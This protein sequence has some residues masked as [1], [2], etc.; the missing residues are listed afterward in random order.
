[1]QN[2]KLLE[3]LRYIQPEE[4]RNYL[5]F[6]RS[7]FYASN[8]LPERLFNNIYKYHP[9]YT[10]SMLSKEKAFKKIFPREKY[11]AHKMRKLMHELKGL[12]E[13]Y[14]IARQVQRDDFQKKQLLLAEYRN[15]NMYSQFKK[16]TTDLITE[17]EASPHRD[18]SFYKNMHALQEGFYDHPLTN[19]EKK[20]ISFLLS[21]MENLDYYYLLH[22]QRFRYALIWAKK[23]LNIKAVPKS[24]K[25]N[26]ETMQTL[27]LF[28]MYD[29][30]SQ[31]HKIPEDDALYDTAEKT[32]KDQIDQLAK[33]DQ[34]DIIRILTNH[35][36]NQYNRG[37]TELQSKLFELHQFGL[38]HELFI[39]NQQ[40]GTHLFTNVVTI[41]ILEQK[42]DW[43]EQFIKQYALY[44]A[45]NLRADTVH[46]SQ[47][48]LSLHRKQYQRTI[49][50][51]QTYKFS[52]ILLVLRSKGILLRACFELFSQDSTY[53]D[54]LI[55]QIEAFKKFIRRHQFI[56]EPK[57][58]T[59]LHF[60]SF[61]Q[62]LATQYLKR[63]LDQTLYHQI[64]VAD[65]IVLKKWLLQQC[66][67]LLKRMG[68]KQ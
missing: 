58:Q 31:M 59:Y 23:L 64:E 33:K 34:K 20:N 7:P 26:M 32:F 22:R 15:R 38:T 9:D 5:K 2:S 49:Q 42:F 37:R 43:A 50:L 40:M 48:Q 36:S 3:L 66:R 51:L 46:L 27:P 52:E 57:K 30:L 12:T 65:S 14:L 67:L 18:I 54:V 28:Q 21:A 13:A 29:L 8:D 61:T 19:K 63:E 6:L 41:G 39:E 16:L 53:Y 62:K 11:N 56:S 17:L 10:S 60:S 24:L 35:L 4:I 68:K 55:A 45:D 47:A 1:M 44:L 25:R